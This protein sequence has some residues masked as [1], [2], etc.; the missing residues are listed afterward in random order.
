M[1][2]DTQK[3]D[4][5]HSWWLPTMLLAALVVWTVLVFS[6]ALTRFDEGLVMALRNTDNSSVPIGPEWVTPAAKA[7]THLADSLPMVVAAVLVLLWLLWRRRKQLPLA[8]AVS[9]GGIYLLNPLLKLVFGRARPE[10]V[11][12]LVH[13]ASNSYPSGHALRSAVLF[14]VLCL[15]AR[16]WPGRGLATV[17]APLA[18]FLIVAVGA[19]RVIL[20]VHWPSDI[21]ASWLMVAL[22]LT[23]WWP[24]LAPKAATN[25]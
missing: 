6:G 12:Q 10:L 11:E 23:Y 1:Q 22:W 4:N 16:A 14:A 3:S 9:I 24:R 2:S 18:V 21:V 7:A 17:L 20:G 8:A 13:A 15:I 25:T 5:G 19:S